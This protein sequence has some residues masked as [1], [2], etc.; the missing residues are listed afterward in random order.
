M[1]YFGPPRIT[2]SKLEDTHPPIWLPVFIQR[3]PPG[4]AVGGGISIRRSSVEII[5]S[6]N[7]FSGIYLPVLFKLIDL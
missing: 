1:V 6:M 3:D 2:W 4:G 7:F 5:S